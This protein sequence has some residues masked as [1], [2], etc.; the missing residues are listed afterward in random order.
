MPSAAS[1]SHSSLLLPAPSAAGQPKSFFRCS[2][3]YDRDC[4]DYVADSSSATCPNCGRKM[5][6]ELEYVPP[7]ADGSW[8]NVQKVAS[9]E[10]FVQRAVTYT[11]RTTSR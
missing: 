5:S 7:E 9:S 1:T 2:Y 4:Y 10:G 11:V 3:Y 8:R 6:R